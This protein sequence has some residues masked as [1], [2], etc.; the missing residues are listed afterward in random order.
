MFGFLYSNSTS[1]SLSIFWLNFLN[2]SSFYYFLFFNKV[3]AGNEE[4]Y[5]LGELKRVGKV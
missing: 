3:E 2:N 5:I 1:L 4:L